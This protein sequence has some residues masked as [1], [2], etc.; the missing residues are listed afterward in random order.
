MKNGQNC[1]TQCVTLVHVKEKLCDRNSKPR[2]GEKLENYSRN[3]YACGVVAWGYFCYMDLRRKF[4]LSR[5]LNHF[6][7]KSDFKTC[8]L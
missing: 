1:I 8:S 4:C 3:Y 7:D 6:C 2:K 5:V